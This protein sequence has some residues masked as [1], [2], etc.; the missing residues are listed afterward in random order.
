VIRYNDSSYACIYMGSLGRKR[1][2]Y[3][4][5]SSLC[6]VIEHAGLK[7]SCKLNA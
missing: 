5:R 4:V 6:V 3:V 1:Q 7:Q 2:R